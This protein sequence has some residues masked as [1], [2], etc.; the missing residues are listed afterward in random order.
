MRDCQLVVNGSL[1]V[2]KG[3]GGKRKWYEHTAIGTPSHI[4]NQWSHMAVGPQRPFQIDGL[5]CLDGSMESSG[6][7]GSGDAACGPSAA[8]NVR[9]RNV[10]DGTI[11][12]DFAR[13]TGRL[14][15]SEYE[16]EGDLEG[17]ELN[18][19]QGSCMGPGR[20]VAVLDRDV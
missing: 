14:E 12:L 18:S 7:G 15:T 8:F 2:R 20:A 6:L 10:F 4:R 5:A 19:R 3:N 17:N 13:Y 9:E 11:A 16:I 1:V